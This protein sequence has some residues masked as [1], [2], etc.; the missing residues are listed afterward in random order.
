[1]KKL[2]YP[3]MLAAVLACGCASAQAPQEET[4]AQALKDEKQAAQ[5]DLTRDQIHALLKKA[6]AGD[7]A[8]LKTLNAEADKGNP[9]AQCDLGNY[10]AE[11]Y[12]NRQNDKHDYDQAAQWYRK[13]AKQGYAEAQVR[14]GSLYISGKGVAR[15]SGQAVR[16]YFKAM[17]QGDIR[18]EG[19]VGFACGRGL[20]AASDYEQAA[21]SFRKV[22]EQGNAIAQKNLGFLYEKGCGVAQD[23]GQAMQWYRKAAQQGNTRAQIN[24]G[25]MYYFGK[26]APRDKVLAYALY[27]LSAEGIDQRVSIAEGDM[28]AQEIESGKALSAK[29]SEPGNLLKALDKYLAAH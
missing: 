29:M 19:S 13:A 10:Y 16:W 23:F 4:S 27:S 7:Q 25:D 22:A 3:F 17:E 18:G 2:I 6:A 15:D 11:S 12:D 28:T 5:A 26:G 14:L 9:S 20:G 21:Q 8:A 1:M 24:L